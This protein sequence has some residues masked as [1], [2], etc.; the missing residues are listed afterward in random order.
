MRQT[1]THIHQGVLAMAV[2]PGGIMH[3]NDMISLVSVMQMWV[4]VNIIWRDVNIVNK[5]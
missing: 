1:L 3:N 2:L 5:S 4:V